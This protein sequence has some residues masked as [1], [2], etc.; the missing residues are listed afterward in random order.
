MYSLV[1]DVENDN[2]P[3]ITL[4]CRA[5]CTRQDAR[6]AGVGKGSELMPYAGHQANL[7]TLLRKPDTVDTLQLRA[8]QV[9]AI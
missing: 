3:G 9:A 2:V 1:R 7:A 8:D 4:R 5:H 6:R